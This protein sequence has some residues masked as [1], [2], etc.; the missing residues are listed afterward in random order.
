MFFWDRVFVHSITY[1]YD[2]LLNLISFRN[3]TFYNSIFF[4]ITC[5]E[6]EAET[7]AVKGNKTVTKPLTNGNANAKVPQKKP[8]DSR[9]VS[10]DMIF[11]HYVFSLKINHNSVF[12][13]RTILTSLMVRLL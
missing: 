12:S 4:D 13:A 10:L 9:C 5:L 6:S 1:F 2:C 3:S 11:N 8:A 7:P